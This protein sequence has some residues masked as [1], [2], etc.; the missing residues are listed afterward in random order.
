MT[1]AAASVQQTLG[2]ATRQGR[3]ICRKEDWSKISLLKKRL[4]V[5]AH[6]ARHVRLFKSRIDLLLGHDL[7]HEAILR[8]KLQTFTQIG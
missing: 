5:L 6:E 2:P 7:I 8:L 3:S 4:L 1:V